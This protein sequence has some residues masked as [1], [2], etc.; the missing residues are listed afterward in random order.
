MDLKKNVIHGVDVKEVPTWKDVSEFIW[1][2]LMTIV[3][4]QHFDRLSKCSREGSLH[5]ILHVTVNGGGLREGP[6]NPRLVVD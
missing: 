3:R 6:W 1:V 4:K 2:K 5:L